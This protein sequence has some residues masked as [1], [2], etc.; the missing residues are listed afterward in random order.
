MTMTTTYKGKQLFL[1]VGNGC[2]EC[3][4]TGNSELCRDLP[5]CE[6][7]AEVGKDRHTCWVDAERFAKWVAEE[8]ME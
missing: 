3:V 1:I 5:E 6:I 7:Y 4:A 2:N 8:R